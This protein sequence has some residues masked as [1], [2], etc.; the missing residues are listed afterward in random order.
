VEA[1]LKTSEHVVGFVDIGT[2][3]V[4]LLVVRV[5]PNLSY[6]VIS[7]EKEVVRLG[8]EE[9]KDGLLKPEAMNRTFL[10]CRKFTELA[11]TYGAS[12]IIA[13]GTSAIREAKNQTEFLQKLYIEA[14]LN[15]HVISGR[16]EA[17][18]LYCG[19]SSGVYMGEEK[20]I[21]IDVGGG[22]TE[23]AIGNQN[24]CFYV[25]SLKLGAIRL[26]TQF[27]GEGWTEKVNRK[28]YKHIKKQVSG[29]LLRTTPHVKTLAPKIAYGSSGTA[30]N[31]AEIT[32]RMFKKQENGTKNPVLSLKNLSKMATR[33]CSLPL[34]ERK[35]IPGI[36][37]DR[38]DIIIA[39]AAI[40]ETLLEEFGIEEINITQRELRDGLLVDYLSTFEG[41]QEFQ[42]TPARNRSV[43]QL[44]RSCNYDEKHAETVAA[45]ALQLFDSGKKIGLHDFG[46]EERELQRYAAVLHDVG[47]FLSFNDHQFHSHYIIS[48]ADLLG[49]DKEEIETMANIAKFHRKK[50]PSKKAL[51]TT[52]LEERSKRI[53]IV[54]S[55]FLRLAEK[56]D[57]SHCGLVK[58]AEFRNI[59]EDRVL[60]TLSSDTD[61]SMEE[62]SIVQ[63]G[64]AFY[65]AFGKKLDVHCEETRKVPETLTEQANHNIQQ[66]KTAV[67]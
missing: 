43:L 48:N 67:S 1:S 57:R 12:S 59:E 63:N 60:L 61:C 31:L 37:P 49:F 33:L 10:V 51:K 9:F 64:P 15:V 27:I 47:D 17:R 50:F 56:L 28:V 30:I 62:W 13:V 38:A 16:E 23:I 42:K 34:E 29:M 36:N 2:N 65:A 3:S 44:G 21:F 19:I 6:T 11:K 20:A 35:E 54:L 26:T 39:G 46:V 22:S 14:G 45:L 40:I 7:Q 52:D 58:K 8:Q 66:H 55:V 4:R 5:N 18:L 32:N 53:V 24:K 25:D 41:F